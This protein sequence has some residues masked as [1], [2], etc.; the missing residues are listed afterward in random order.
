MLDDKEESKNR[1]K[2]IYIFMESLI[3]LKWEDAFPSI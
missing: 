3:G 1:T 2:I